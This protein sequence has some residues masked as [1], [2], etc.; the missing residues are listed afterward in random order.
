MNAGTKVGGFLAGLVVVGV[1]GA[2]VGAVAGPIDTEPAGH[3]DPAGHES[4]PAPG[5]DGA[6]ADDDHGSGPAADDPAPEGEGADGHGGHDA[7]PAGDGAAA[8]GTSATQDGYRLAL[9]P[10][11]DQI[12][13]WVLDPEG[14]PVADTEVLHERPLHLIVVGRDLVGYAHLHPEV[15]TDGMWSVE[16]PALA[17]GSYRVVADLKPVGGPELVLAADLAVPGA[18]DPVAVP[19]AASTATVDDLTVA[20][21]GHPEVGDTDL[22]FTVTR[23]GEPVEP[24][25]YLGARG[26]LVAFRTDDLAYSHVHPH[27]GDEGPIAFTASFPTPGVYRLFL[28]VQVEGTV[29]TFPFTVEVHGHG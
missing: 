2:G 14:V 11:D 18:V 24:E 26:H 21:E 13:L 10:T 5:A 7:E 28:D 6:H 27:D 15:D 12:R 4:E 8:A 19:E 29:R 9:D 22:A 25:P 20:L 23:A 16:R 17:P 1:V 3:D